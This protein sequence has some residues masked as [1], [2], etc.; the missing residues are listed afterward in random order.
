MESTIQ[1]LTEL[2]FPAE[3]FE[4]IFVDDGSTDNSMEQIETFLKLHDAKFTIKLLHNSGARGPGVARNIGISNAQGGWILFL[5]SDDQFVPNALT[6][7]DRHIKLE[8]KESELVFFDGLK[9]G[10]AN[11]KRARICKH[12]KMADNA[13]ATKNAHLEVKSI[14][15]LE[16]DEHV[17]F[18]A[19]KRELIKNQ[20][21]TFGPGIYEDILFISQALVLSQ[22]NSH[23]NQVLYKKFDRPEQITGTFTLNHAETYLRSRKSVWEW[24]RA[25]FLELQH[26]FVS[27]YH[28]GV[29]GAMGILYRRSL[30]EIGVNNRDEFDLNLTKFAVNLFDDFEGI[31][32][33]PRVTKLDSSAFTRFKEVAA[34]GKL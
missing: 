4:V 28:F 18:S 23:L 29:R 24:L 1:A 5:D 17:I 8:G 20:K 13:R 26:N 14:L 31:M 2:H 11:D 34:L 22:S 3:D 25:D 7:L 6:E 15:R 9:M 32:C 27:D 33:A 12:F 10:R 16:F 30:S 21:L 19:F